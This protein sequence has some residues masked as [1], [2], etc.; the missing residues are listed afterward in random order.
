MNAKNTYTAKLFVKY[1]CHTIKFNGWHGTI[2]VAMATKVPSNQLKGK[3][4]KR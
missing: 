2:V 3:P 1:C 4:V